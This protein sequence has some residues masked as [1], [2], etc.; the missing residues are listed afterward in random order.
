[1]FCTHA[2][3]KGGTLKTLA[4]ELSKKGYVTILSVSKKEIKPNKEADFSEVIGEIR[5]ALE[6]Q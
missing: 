2:L 4:N 6:K 3:A 5:K 1:M